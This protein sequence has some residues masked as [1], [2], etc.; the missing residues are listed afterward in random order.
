ML[1]GFPINRILA[2]ETIYRAGSEGCSESMVVAGDMGCWGQ[3]L[4][5]T[6]VAGDKVTGDK[7]CAESVAG[8]K[9]SWGQ[10]LLG[11]KVWLGTRVALSQ[12]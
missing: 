6:R 7:G 3:G 12:W 2:V 9:D 8:G 1:E 10:G 5:G 11:T 4:P